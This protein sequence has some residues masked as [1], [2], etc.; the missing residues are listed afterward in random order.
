MMALKKLIGLLPLGEFISIY[1]AETDELI[2]NGKLGD[3]SFR[4]WLDVK[5]AEVYQ[6][7]PDYK[8]NTLNIYIKK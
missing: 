6:T 3:M 1:D 4:T 7:Y 5:L 2:Y 8:R